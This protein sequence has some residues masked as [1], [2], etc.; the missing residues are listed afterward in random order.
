MKVYIC[1]LC[2]QSEWETIREVEKVLLSE[3]SAKTWVKLETQNE[4]QWREYET[5]D[6][7]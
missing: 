3:K 1:F 7:D 5:F 6:A 2:K 4:F